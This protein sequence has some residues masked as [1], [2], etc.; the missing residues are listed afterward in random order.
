MAKQVKKQVQ[1]QIQRTQH[2][3][4]VAYQIQEASV[5][6]ADEP[7]TVADVWNILDNLHTVF[8]DVD[9]EMEKLLIE[10]MDKIDSQ[11]NI[12]TY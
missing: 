2:G 9:L 1:E 5:Y 12:E 7:L 10:W 11:W 3:D 4:D 6:G 8:M